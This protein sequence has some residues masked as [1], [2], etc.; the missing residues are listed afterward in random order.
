MSGYAAALWVFLAISISIAESIDTGEKGLSVFDSPEYLIHSFV[1]EL[2][3]VK[4]L[5][6]Y[7]RN[8]KSQV[9]PFMYYFKHFYTN[10]SSARKYEYDVST[11]RTIFA[12]KRSIS[13]FKATEYETALWI[14][15]ID[16]LLKLQEHRRQNGISTFHTI[17]SPKSVINGAILGIV[18]LQNVY[19][20]DISTFINNKVDN[21]TVEKISKR[22]NYEFDAM[23]LMCFAIK[24]IELKWY[25][26]ANK[27]LNYINFWS[28]K[29][30]SCILFSNQTEVD[31]WFFRIKDYTESRLLNSD[32]KLLDVS[33]LKYLPFNRKAG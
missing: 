28:C 3:E 6:D 29:K 18:L 2:K 32:E 25:I 23:D 30:I 13:I 8:I 19:Q 26:S 10:K 7:R 4:S 5:L 33:N 20:L 1:V 21:E 27:Y 16:S 22:R 11:C 14:K 15:L 24:A 9:L 12:I 31:E 17:D